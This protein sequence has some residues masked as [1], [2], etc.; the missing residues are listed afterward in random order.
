MPPNLYVTSCAAVSGFLSDSRW[1]L[2]CGPRKP[3]GE[4]PPTVEQT[5]APPPPPS[6]ASQCHYG[7]SSVYACVYACTWL[8]LCCWVTLFGSERVLGGLVVAWGA[9]LLPPA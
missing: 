2:G 1:L 8:P 5:I 9:L 4:G 3:G 7:I 6:R